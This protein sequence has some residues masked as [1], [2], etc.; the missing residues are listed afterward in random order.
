MRGYKNR[1]KIVLWRGVWALM[2]DFEA[3]LG[4][5][6][7][8]GAVLGLL[9]PRGSARGPP[10]WTQLGSQDGAKME[11]KSMQKSIK[12]L[13]HLGMDFWQDFGGFWKAKWSQVGTKINQKSMPIAKCDFLKNRALAAAWAR[14]LRFWGSKLGVNID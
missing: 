7:R 3:L 13:M 2:G 10:I 1:G 8:R 5:S 11:K 12:N 4:A 6:G 14:F 9:G